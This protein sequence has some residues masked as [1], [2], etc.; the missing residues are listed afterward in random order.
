MPKITEKEFDQA[1]DKYNKN[2]DNLEID[3]IDSFLKRHG[4][5]HEAYHG[6]ESEATKERKKLLKECFE[7]SKGEKFED[8]ASGYFVKYYREPIKFCLIDLIPSFSLTPKER[9][10]L[11]FPGSTRTGF[12]NKKDLKMLFKLKKLLDKHPEL[13]KWWQ[14]D[15]DGINK[16]LVLTKRF[17]SFADFPNRSHL[18]FIK[19]NLK[20]LIYC[21]DEMGFNPKEQEDLIYD[22]FCEF[23]F[24]DYGKGGEDY[25][26]VNG[27]MS[28]AE[29][30]QREN[31]KKIR[32]SSIKR[33]NIYG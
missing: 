9:S 6:H 27:E 31:I 4:C 5:D 23:E 21:L 10:A 15:I 22:L 3:R 19:E 25:I 13:I 1:W 16:D 8:F 30:K 20:G 32:L 26:K 14:I 17:D 24:E 33:T 2:K 11:A 7:R 12:D 28:D 18:H 29:V